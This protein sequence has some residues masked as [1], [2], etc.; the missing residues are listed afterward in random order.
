[1]VTCPAEPEVGQGAVVNIKGLSYRYH[2]APIRGARR[3]EV[4]DGVRSRRTQLHA[5]DCSY[6]LPFTRLDDLARILRRSPHTIKRDVRRKTGAAPVK[7]TK[8]GS[9]AL[10]VTPEL[11]GL[12][13][14]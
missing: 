5:L 3:F 14:A 13:A 10:C 12:I 1:M 7:R 8:V 2:L 4:D 11:E 6:D 9:S